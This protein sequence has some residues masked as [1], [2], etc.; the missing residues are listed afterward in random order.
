VVLATKFGYVGP[1]QGR[2]VGV[3]Y[4]MTLFVDGSPRMAR[5]R[6]DTTCRVLLRPAPPSSPNNV[7]AELWL[8]PTILAQVVRGKSGLMCGEEVMR[9]PGY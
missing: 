1:D 9:P 4:R 8:S 5:A 6:V 7:V 2:R 3:G